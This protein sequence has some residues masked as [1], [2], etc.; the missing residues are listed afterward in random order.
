M[1]EKQKAEDA[2]KLREAE[3]ARRMQM[4]QG[5]DLALTISKEDFTDWEFVSTGLNID[6]NEDDVLLC[7]FVG[8]FKVGKTFHINKIFDMNLPVVSMTNEGGIIIQDTNGIC[9]VKAPSDIAGEGVIVLDCAGKNAPI[10]FNNQ[11]GMLQQAEE[12]DNLTID[13]CIT[14]ADFVVVVVERVS[15]SSAKFIYHVAK[16]MSKRHETQAGFDKMIVL[17]NY[18]DIESKEE[19]EATFIKYVQET[20]GARKR[21]L[22]IR[23]DAGI[24]QTDYYLSKFEDIAYP[25]VHLPLGRD[26]RPSGNFFN[27]KAYSYVR[28]QIGSINA[29][30][31]NKN[32]KQELV[33]AL[34]KSIDMVGA[35]RGKEVQLDGLKV[36]FI[37]GTK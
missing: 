28:Q 24:V 3:Q 33:K 9:A 7:T 6:D 13:V 23:T 35:L 4:K 16:T 29:R 22:N 14:V 2:M 19:V 30:A 17:H 20:F 11:E 10:R 15:V 18:K 34:G 26:N 1:Q 12:V 5:Y 27:A 32:I 21:S 31:K 25:V 36:N 8:Y 37:D